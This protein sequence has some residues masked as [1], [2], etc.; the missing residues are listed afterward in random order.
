MSKEDVYAYSKILKYQKK[1]YGASLFDYSVVG[2][3]SIFIITLTILIASTANNSTATI[4]FLISAIYLLFLIVGFVDYSSGMGLFRG[5]GLYFASGLVLIAV[6]ISMYVSLAA[7]TVFQGHSQSDLLAILTLILSLFGSIVVSYYLTASS[8][9]RQGKDEMILKLNEIQQNISKMGLS[10]LGSVSAEERALKW[11]QYK[12]RADGIWGENNPLFETSEVLSMFYFT[13][14][15]LDYS[16]KS[17]V[18]GT[19][20]VHTV[21]QTYYLVLEALDTAAREPTYESLLPLL[22][23]SEINPDP[24]ILQNEIFEEFKVNLDQYSEWEFVKDI[25]RYDDSNLQTSEIPIIFVMAKMFYIL[26]DN[27]TAQQCIDIIANTFGILINR[28]ATRFTVVQDKEVSSRLLGIMYNTIIR[29]VRGK[30][31]PIERANIED[32]KMNVKDSDKSDPDMP[33]ISFMAD[34]DFDDNSGPET[35]IEYDMPSIPGMD[36]DLGDPLSSMIGGPDSEAEPQ[37]PIKLSTS[38]AAIRNYVRSKQQIDGSWGGRIDITAECL[39]AVLD[40]ESAE[41]DF[42][43]SGLHY[44]LA[45]QETN[46]SWQ[47][48]IILTSKVITILSRINRSLSV[49]G[50]SDAF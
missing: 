10:T 23:V 13:G 39:R 34:M 32:L 24:S 5:I 20:E 1:R 37:S 14:R 41:T 12:Q 21:E 33:D 26:G 46:G 47:D 2:L 25:E 8:P 16:W 42:V 4:L 17:I 7:D 31:I 49:G 15:G 11:I 6:L 44:L 45:L 50:L 35:N 19:E 48:D 30:Q 27:D 22:I 18:S 29:L 36:M 38:L 3:S 9:S 43:K 40:Q 28:S